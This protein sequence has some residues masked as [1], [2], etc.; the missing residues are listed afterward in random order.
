MIE[1]STLQFLIDLKKNN[2]KE[3]FDANRKRYESAK[4]DVQNITGA[5]I[6]AIGLYVVN[7]G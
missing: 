3:W 5:L 6:K 2:T 4:E 7:H 1:N